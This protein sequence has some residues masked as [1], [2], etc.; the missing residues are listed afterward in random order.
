MEKMTTLFC[1][2]NTMKKIFIRNKF[3][4]IVGFLLFNVVAFAQETNTV[5]EN[6]SSYQLPKIL[7]DPVTYIWLLLGS[8]IIITIYT[9]SHTINVL[10]NLINQSTESSRQTVHAKA[11]VIEISWWSKLGK[12]LTKSVPIE[13]E[14][15][16]L[17]DHDYDGIKELDNQLPPWWKYGFYLTIVFAFV[18]IINYHFSKNGKLQLAEYNDELLK[19]EADKKLMM[20]H[21]TNY[22]TIESV[23]QL[24]DVDALNGGKDVYMKNCKA[25]HGDFAQGNVGPNLTDDFWLHGGGIK[26]VFKTVIEGV[27]SKGMISWKAQLSPKSIQEVSSYILSLHGSNPVSPK[28]PQGERWVEKENKVTSDTSK[29][30]TQIK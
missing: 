12:A 23:L 9:L 28:E 13:K 29:S 27:P 4:L 8:I 15:D 2:K 6:S 17:L 22:V 25:C 21:N 14:K 18:Y 20:E 7:W 1:N 10:S 16:V 11:K 5:M 26:N 19:T 24:V 3:I 30:L